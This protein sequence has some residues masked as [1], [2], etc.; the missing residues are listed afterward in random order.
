MLPNPT[1]H[2]FGLIGLLFAALAI[3]FILYKWRSDKSMT[4]SL[5]AATNSQA[6]IFFGVAATITALFLYPFLWWWFMPTLQLPSLFGWCVGIAAICHLLLGW[7]PDKPGKLSQI[8]NVIA[9]IAGAMIIP[10]TIMIA[11]STAI[12]PILKYAS[13]IYLALSI[14]FIG[15]YFF[16]RSI[17]KHSLIYQMIFYWGFFVIVLAAA[18]LR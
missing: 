15:L 17:R 3:G 2:Y 11:F 12:S 4:L 18:Y 6:L 1:L 13:L 10:F 9:F 7:V 8:H 5:H 16:V 14:V